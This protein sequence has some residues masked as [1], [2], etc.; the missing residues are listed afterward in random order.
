MVR[1]K[2]QKCQK[3]D[4]TDG[5]REEGARVWI[6]ATRSALRVWSAGAGRVSQPAPHN[7]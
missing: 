2:L 5:V 1:E 7:T 3:E 4:K 6:E